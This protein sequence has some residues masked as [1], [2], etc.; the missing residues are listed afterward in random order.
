MGGCDQ[1]LENL[2]AGVA[3]QVE[4]QAAFAAIEGFVVEAVGSL[5]SRRHVPADIA[6]GRWVFDA[7]HLRTEVRQ[8]Q[9][10]ER[11]GAELLDGDDPHALERSSRHAQ[12]VRGQ[13][14]C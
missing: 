9:G 8:L 14:A 6:A 12:M 3:L 5:L 13:G 10:P 4:Q 2:P 11:P 1:T 7:D